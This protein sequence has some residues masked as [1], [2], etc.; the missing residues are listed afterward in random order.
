MLCARARD[1]RL[2]GRIG[3]V[4]FEGDRE[5]EEKLTLNG[6]LHSADLIWLCSTRDSTY[7]LLSIR[8]S[9]TPSYDSPM[10]SYPNDPAQADSNTPPDS[11]SLPSHA[12]DAPER[13]ANNDHDD[14]ASKKKKGSKRRKVNH[15]CLYCRRSHMTCDEGR[16]CQRW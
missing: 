15:A 5:E 1:A 8:G 6:H 9:P 11:G 14:D 16:P 2:Y 3:S 10:S 7:F 4:G 12:H 13:P